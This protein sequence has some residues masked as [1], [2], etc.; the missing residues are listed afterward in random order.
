[1]LFGS[2]MPQKGITCHITLRKI[3]QDRDQPHPDKFLGKLFRETQNI[4][5][6]FVFVVFFVGLSTDFSV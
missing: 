6:F 1:M 3:F 5:T 2:I 4:G